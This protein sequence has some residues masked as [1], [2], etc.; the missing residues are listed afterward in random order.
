MIAPVMDD[1]N[2]HGKLLSVRQFI[3]ACRFSGTEPKEIARKMGVS[4]EH[5]QE[6]LR[7]RSIDQ[8]LQ[9]AAFEDMSDALG[10]LHEGDMLEAV[11]AVKANW[12]DVVGEWREGLV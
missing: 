3:F 9:N 7:S 4:V 6:V 12:C 10:I 2:R 11:K 5:V 1:R 8:Q